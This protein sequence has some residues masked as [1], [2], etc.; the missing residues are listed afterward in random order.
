MQ[1][2]QV[3]AV[4][5][6]LLEAR[7]DALGHLVGRVVAQ[8][9]GVLDLGGQREA[10]LL[11]ADLASKGLLLAVDVDARRVDLAVPALLEE[12]EDRA[13]LGGGGDAGACGFD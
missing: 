7:L 1:V 10:P 13:V 4:R 6:Q 8:A 9:V 2:Q 5:P 12:V 11:P 3:D